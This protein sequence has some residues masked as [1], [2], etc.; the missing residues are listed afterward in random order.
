VNLKF[1]E[2]I[3]FD[4][5]NRGSNEAFNTKILLEQN[6]K[7]DIIRLNGEYELIKRALNDPDW[8]KKYLVDFSE[9]EK[10]R[11]NTRPEL[12]TDEAK[13][14]WNGIIPGP[15][16]EG[17]FWSLWCN[18]KVCEKI[19]I[20]VKQFGMTAD[21]FIGYIKAVHE[22]NLKNP[23]NQIVALYESGGWRTTY[24]I[25][26]QLFSSLMADYSEFNDK[27]F[28]DT[29]LNAWAKTLDVL[30]KLSLYKPLDPKWRNVDWNSTKGALLNGECL[31]YVNGSWMYNIWQTI[32]EQKIHDCMPTEFPVF[33][34]KTAYPASYNIIWAVLKNAPHRDEAVKFLLSMNEPDFA[35]SWMRD[36]KCPTGIEGSLADDNFGSDQFEQFANYIQKTYKNKYYQVM[37]SGHYILDNR[38][39]DLTSLYLMDVFE[40]KMTSKEAMSKIKQ[41]LY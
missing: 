34:N 19:G 15:Y 32:D 9:I 14:K 35:D 3:Y 36:T 38:F 11:E 37:E 18:K 26:F 29:R 13:R 31:F 10:F 21:D 40:G 22:F 20:N 30:E 4:V 27:Q 28:S 16:V 5:V 23:N 2:E 7:W 17:V 39:N 12:L 24:V 33:G 6:P 8:A 41:S 1:P 25:A